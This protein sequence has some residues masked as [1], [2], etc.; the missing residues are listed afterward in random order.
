MSD[1]PA[2][3]WADVQ[4]LR[5]REDH[6]EQSTPPSHAPS[7][8][9]ARGAEE[10]H[11]AAIATLEHEIAAPW[12][13]DDVVAPWAETLDQPAERAPWEEPVREED[14]PAPAAQERAPLW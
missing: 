6:A 7:R 10:Q 1:P 8:R 2:P 11:D 5:P 4:H 9:F 13:T 14:A 12:A 3:W